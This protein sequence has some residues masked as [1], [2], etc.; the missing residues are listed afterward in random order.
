MNEKKVMLREKKF[1]RMQWFPKVGEIYA[2]K[3]FNNTD[4]NN[5]VDDWIIET[6]KRSKGN[7]VFLDISDVYQNNIKIQIHEK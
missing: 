3:I 2:F 4:L 6:S 7:V 5:I 1:L